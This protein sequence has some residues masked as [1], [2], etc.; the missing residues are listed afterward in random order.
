MKKISLL[1]TYL[2]EKRRLKYFFKIMKISA[3]ML[4]LFVFSSMAGT[5]T[6]QNAKVS[7]HMMNVPLEEVLTEIEHQTNYL[8]IYNSDVNTTNR[9][10][11]K[12]KNKQ[13][14]NVLS[15][16][17]QSTSVTYSMEGRHIVLDAQ[18]TPENANPDQQKPD[19]T[20]TGIV[21]DNT[22][23]GLAGVSISLK[24]TS[25][26]TITDN[27]GQFS[28]A[29]PDSENDILV[30]SYIGYAS[31]EL[32][33]GSRNS[34][35][36]ELS[37]DMFMMDEV[38]VVGYGTQKKPNLTGAVVQIDSKV[39]ESRPV[40]SAITAL[41]GSMPG[42]NINPTNGNP[43]QDLD[44]NIRG[45]TSINGGGP[46][47]LVDGIESSLKL[48]NPNDIETVS[49]LKDAAASAIYGVRA[50][51][52]V[53]LIT[54]KKGKADGKLSIN[55]SGNYAWAKATYMPE[56][57]GNS[58]D[59]ATFVNQSLVNNNAAPL[60]GE[61]QLKGI[62]AR[63]KDPSLPEYIFEGKQYYPVGYRDWKK[64]L[65]NDYSPRQTHNVNISGGNGKTS[66][67]AS[68]AHLNQ[69]GVIK[70]N[71]DVYKRSNVNLYVQ[72]NTYDWMKLSFRTRY[73][74]SK[75]DEPYHYNGNSFWHQMLFSSP[76][77]GG[78]W[79]GD[80]NYPE[81]DY[82]IGRYFQD[83]N[84]VPLLLYGGRTT[85]KQHEIVLTP[86]IDITPLKGW[87][88][89]LDYSYSKLF[90][91]DVY[92]KKRMSDYLVHHTATGLAPHNGPGG[93]TD[94]YQKRQSQKTYSS[95][96]AYSDYE[97][98]LTDKHHFK[99]MAGFNQ[100]LTQYNYYTA[101][102]QMMLN[103]DLPG[104]GLGTGNQLV[105]ETGYEWALRGG[106]ARVNYDFE[107]RYLLELVGRYDGTSRFP[108]DNR[109]VFL[110]SLSAGWR[111]SEESFMQFVKPLFDNIKLRAS[112]GTLGNQMLSSSAWS[113]NAKY[114]PYIPFLTNG[115]S[116]YYLFGNV[117]TELT[118]NPPSS[119]LPGALTWEK[120]SSVNGGL[121]LTLLS[122]RLDMSFEMFRRTTSDML[123]QQTYPEVLGTNAP[124]VNAGEL[125]TKGWEFSVSWRD[126]IGDDLSY[127]VNFNIYD[128][129]AEITKWK[130]GTG[131]VTD[132]YEGK[133]VGE[134]WGYVTERFLT[135]DDFDEKGNLKGASQ[136]SIASNWKPGDIK[137]KN[138]DGNEAV[139]N[140]GANTPEDPGD[141][142]VVGNST[143]R[144]SYSFG[145]ELT[146]K[147][148]S[149][150]VF[151]QGVGKRDIWPAAEDF[152]PT[153][154]QYYNT[155]ERFLTECWTPENT[156]AYYALPR[157]RGTQNRQT[158]TKYLQDGS[159]LRLK[160][161][162]I[163]YDLPKE[164]IKK[165][166]LGKLQVYLSGE[167]LWEISHLVGPYDPEG[168]FDN[169]SLGVGTYAY[170]FQRVYSLGL[171]LTF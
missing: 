112:Y 48:V 159:Y 134:I 164:W 101:E 43:N 92:N 169:G 162:T 120:V 89:H 161:L 59:H 12:V 97:F 15:D 25:I 156:D 8:F 4:F 63:L 56:F 60:Y 35:T 72:N 57:A 69:T 74:T 79:L 24:G 71:P 82:L 44:I 1:N 99:V 132:Y 10:S 61:A 111:L 30:F 140:T 86:A 107:N 66:F 102:R 64:I 171:N 141:R 118:I 116:D 3:F 167:N 20:V 137:Y 117:G 41:Q 19:K 77:R 98:S 90:S 170:P 121:D 83:Q 155:Q 103:P 80:P 135:P 11:V 129:Q 127:R 37:E 6:S 123:L 22:G 85:M 38:V 42:V 95:F 110:P 104:L 88:I 148:L 73:N 70:I 67:Y 146:W 166:K 23:E 29:F 13:V 139:I 149:A 33:V 145:G 81:Y 150:S 17:F 109:F 122:Q 68:L 9:V 151:F 128:A 152:W 49:V 168:I 158:Q 153:A 131:T 45:T 143:A 34:L 113:G 165:A 51:F 75:M 28:I 40:T 147:N 18:K 54:T 53:V 27:S 154:T 50:A 96:N 26:R 157:A 133:K 115:T 7:I 130:G 39:F 52:G 46:L 62:E 5:M 138:L 58:L 31:R 87:N 126:R 94:S 55:Y 136:A 2:P 93:A 65:I 124:V 47:I 106:F 144:Y 76:L 32:K 119:L 160:N 14:G 91:N 78:Q 36:V 108:K 84:Q 21:T 125:E 100:E 163:A 114:Y 105:S 142:K 16:L